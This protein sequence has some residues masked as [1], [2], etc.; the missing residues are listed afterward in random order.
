MEKGYVILL[1]VIDMKKNGEIVKKKEKEYITLIV[2]KDMKEIFCDDGF[3]KIEFG[4]AGIEK[5]AFAVPY[6]HKENVTEKKLQS[7][8]SSKTK[9]VK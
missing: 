3:I 4:Q 9:Y 5:V 7:I 1:M 8:L 6:F 2:V